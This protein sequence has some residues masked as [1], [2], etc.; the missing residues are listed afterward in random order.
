MS[1]RTSTQ[2]DGSYEQCEVAVIQFQRIELESKLELRLHD[3]AEWLPET[4]Q[5]LTCDKAP[6]ICH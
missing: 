4:T 2:D 1:Q 3:L 6:P 5:E